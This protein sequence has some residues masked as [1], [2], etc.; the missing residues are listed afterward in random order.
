[1]KTFKQFNLV[2]E[3]M[4]DDPCWDGYEMVGTKKKKGK[5]VPNC[6][7]EVNEVSR[8]TVGSY[9]QKAYAEKDRLQQ[10]DK[11]DP[12]MLS[13]KEKKKM[14]KRSKGI[15][16][17]H[18]AFLNKES[19]I[20][21]RH[22]NIGLGDDPEHEKR[23]KHYNE[24]FNVIQDSYKK[25]EGGYGGLGSGSENERK[26]IHDDITHPNHAIKATRRDG[27]I[28]HVSI[29][30]KTPYGRKSIASGTDSSDQ[31]KKDLKVN[32]RQDHEMKKRNA[33]GEVSGAPEHIKRKMGVPVVD[34]RHVEK[35]L[36]KKI[37]IQDK[38][39]YSRMLGGHPHVKTLMGNPKL[40]D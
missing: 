33:Y 10:M 40:P 15:S 34:T 31:G 26:A 20:A 25:V 17:A 5:E 24:I 2:S 36:G 4:K 32:M 35:I 11:S 9:L 16:L 39:R 14:E 1:M 28:V 38:E 27:K 23:K 6:V 19:Y 3:K 12:K 8:N 37:K 7:P 29:Y 13:N 18:R 30:K 21:E 22:I